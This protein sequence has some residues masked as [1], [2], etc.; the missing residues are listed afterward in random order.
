M[1][2][3]ETKPYESATDL[4]GAY[5]IVPKSGA[6]ERATLLGFFSSK[7]G[8]AIERVAGMVG[9][10]KDLRDLYYLKSDLEQAY[11]RGVPYSAA[12]R[13]ALQV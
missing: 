10:L 11:A 9:H 4:F 8:I 3:E 5:R 12:F 6:S 7:T 13:K 1:K 2:S